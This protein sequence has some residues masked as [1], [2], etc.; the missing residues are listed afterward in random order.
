MH[1]HRAPREEGP[2]RRRLHEQHLLL[3]VGDELR[4]VRL[5][6]E[7]LHGHVG[8]R[9]GHDAPLARHHQAPETQQRHELGA[10]ADDGAEAAVNW[11][12]PCFQEPIQL[13]RLG[14]AEFCALLLFRRHHQSPD[15]HD[16]RAEVRWKVAH[17]RVAFGHQTQEGWGVHDVVTI[18]S[19]GRVVG[20]AGKPQDPVQDGN[21]QLSGRTH[22]KA[23]EQLP[24][25]NFHAPRHGIGHAHRRDVAAWSP[26]VE[27]EHDDWNA[28]HLAQSQSVR[29][30]Q[31]TAQDQVW[32][33][34]REQLVHCLEFL[35]LV[36]RHSL[37]LDGCDC[38][39]VV[40]FHGLRNTGLVH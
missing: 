24:A 20:F 21:V 28:P 36:L 35:F 18:L 3:G 40:F 7:Q 5:A 10:L 17:Q 39:D 4:G 22:A 32:L 6:L 37:F 34:R 2:V 25:C 27:A 12:R 13:R 15:L 8:P 29:Y 19:I 11:R 14:R 1:N 30:A 23:Q 31:G 38:H 16:V 33:E 9:G 26:A